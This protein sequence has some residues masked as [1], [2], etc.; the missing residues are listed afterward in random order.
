MELFSYKPWGGCYGWFWRHHK[1]LAVGAIIS[2]IAFIKDAK[3]LV[4]AVSQQTFIHLKLMSEDEIQHS[5]KQANARVYWDDLLAVRDTI[6]VH[7]VAP[8]PIG[9]ET[10]VTT[11][12][13][14]SS[15]FT[16]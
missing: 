15:L 8:N 11:N 6:H 16:Y 9:I 10:K 13:G 1:R 5:L 14:K 2:S 4:E 12:G 3:S 7:F